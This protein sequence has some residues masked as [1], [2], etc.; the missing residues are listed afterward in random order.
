MP[1][2]DRSTIL[3]FK[4]GRAFRREGTNT[5][6]PHAEKGAVVIAKG[7]DELLHFM[8]KNRVTEETDEDL[9]LFPTDASFTRVSQ[10]SGRVYVLKFSSSDQRHFFWMQDGSAARDEEFAYHVDRLLQI[11]GYIPVW[12]AAAPEA[13]Q[14]STSAQ[15]AASASTATPEQLAQLRALVDQ[16]SGAT[17][18]EPE[19]FLSDVLTPANFTPLFTS[20][21]EL[22]STIFPHLPPDLPTPPSAEVLT[23]I[24]SSPQFRGAVLG[25]DRALRTGLLGGLMRQL[26]LPE[27]AGTS[28]EAFL[29][30]IREQ[31]REGNAGAESMDTD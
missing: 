14:A 20:H 5:V 21:P 27:E 6:E 30:A 24:V 25:F 8:W 22:I 4:A 26:G 3:A 18:F 15:P 13:P 7:E 28:V 10:A 19:F 1:L 17:H 23:Q 31:A 2:T 29:R 9:I 16:M 11:P 12:Q